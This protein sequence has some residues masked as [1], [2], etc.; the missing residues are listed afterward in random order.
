M[1]LKTYHKIILTLSSYIHVKDQ[2][3]F[4]YETPERTACL[5]YL[6]DKDERKAIEGEDDDFS[7]S[8]VELQT[9][10][11]KQKQPLQVDFVSLL[12]G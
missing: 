4:H 11:E 10:D 8:K 12:C 5:L 3:W 1:D 7:C 2:E 6:L 9:L